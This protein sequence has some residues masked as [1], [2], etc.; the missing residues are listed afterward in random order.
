[1]EGDGSGRVVRGFLDS[2]VVKSC[3]M[4]VGERGLLSPTTYSCSAG[5]SITETSCDSEPTR[6]EPE[7][8]PEPAS[9]FITFHGELGPSRTTIITPGVPAH[10][11]KIGIR[12]THEPQMRVS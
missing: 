12:W 3:E 4:D 1:M 8:E 10:R 5:A 9:P 6:P 2:E 7:P 11:C